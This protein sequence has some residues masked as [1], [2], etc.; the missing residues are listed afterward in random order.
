ME[1]KIKIIKERIQRYEDSRLQALKDKN[2]YYAG[3]MLSR[4]QGLIEALTILNSENVNL[5]R[6]RVLD[7]D[8]LF[9]KE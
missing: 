3:I 5:S 4:A 2:H 7:I 9:K 1:S 8:T 6:E